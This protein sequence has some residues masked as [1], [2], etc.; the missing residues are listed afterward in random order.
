MTTLART[1]PFGW[2][3][4]NMPEN[5]YLIPGIAALLL[6]LI[7]PLYWILIAIFAGFD[8]DFP[9]FQARS[10][11]GF[12]YFVWLIL[13]ALTVYVYLSLKGA[14]FER[15]SYTRL[16]IPIYLALGSTVFSYGGLALLEFIL[17]MFNEGMSSSTGDALIGGMVAVFF[18]GIVIQGIIDILIGAFLLRDTQELPDTLR[19]FAIVTLVNGIFA[20]TIIFAF[21]TLFTVPI[22]AVVLG[23]YFLKQTD[24]IE[25]V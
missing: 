3:E 13:G 14:L 17:V 23:I 18:G 8:L 24:T 9:S 5:N 21:A 22:A 6:A 11:L 7:F 2:L 12:G 1:R 4:D 16:N 19:I 15:H 10:G 20:L 25:V